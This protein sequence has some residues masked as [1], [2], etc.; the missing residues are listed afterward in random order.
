MVELSKIG[1][2]LSSRPAGAK[3]APEILPNSGVKKLYTL[4]R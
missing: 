4:D 3:M 2:E 1:L